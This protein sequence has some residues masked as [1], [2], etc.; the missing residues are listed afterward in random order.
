[1]TR[2]E[3]LCDACMKREPQAL[4]IDRIYRDLPLRLRQAIS[5]Y[6]G[7]P[8]GSAMFPEGA[9]KT[10]TAYV[11]FYRRGIDVV[12]GKQRTERC[13]RDECLVLDSDKIPYFT[14]GIWVER[15]PHSMQGWW[16]FL[17]ISIESANEESADITI[18]NQPGRITINLRDADGY[19]AVAATII[20]RLI[21]CMK[22]AGEGRGPYGSI[23]FLRE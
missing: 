9:M 23:G 22:Q 16:L 12:S 18:E 17:K 13:E 19:A 11:D 6:L 21:E 8:A 4:A 10:P 3:E 5:D 7:A 2:Y 1:M 20:D 14:L 15:A